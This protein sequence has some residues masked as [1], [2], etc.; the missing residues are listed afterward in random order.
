MMFLLFFQE[1][2]DNITK[3]VV[4]DLLVAIFVVQQFYIFFPVKKTLQGAG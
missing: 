2:Q 3:R 4:P 1:K